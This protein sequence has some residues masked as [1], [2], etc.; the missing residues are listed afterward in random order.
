MEYRL[1]FLTF[2]QKAPTGSTGIMLTNGGIMWYGEDG[3]FPSSAELGTKLPT[4][5]EFNTTYNHRAASQDEIDEYT[6]I[7][8]TPPEEPP[9]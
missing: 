5:P 4:D 6:T 3:N 9:S 8:E 2:G 1:F 7:L